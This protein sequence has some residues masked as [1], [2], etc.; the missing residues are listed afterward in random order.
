MA[1]I[2]AISGARKFTVTLH[3]GVDKEQHDRPENP[4]IT[5]EFET[6]A[7]LEAFCLGAH[8]VAGWEFEEIPKGGVC[9]ICG[10]DASGATVRRHR[11]GDFL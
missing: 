1:K 9:G 8:A 4:P 7:E 6:A 11:R 5:Y 2:A 10:A 3:M